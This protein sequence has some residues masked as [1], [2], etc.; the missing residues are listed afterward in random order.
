M[1]PSLG[2]RRGLAG[3]GWSVFSI[4]EFGRKFRPISH[5]HYMDP[6]TIS[7]LTGLATNYFAGFTMPVIQRFFDEAFGRKPSL[8]DDLKNA[9]SHADYERVFRE[10]VGVIDAAA[11][12][13]SIA[14]DSAFLS[15]VRGIRFDHQHGTVTIQ[16][17]TMMAPL[18]QMG[19]TNGSRGV[20]SL[21]ANTAL[22]SGGASIQIG[23]GISIVISG[24][25]SI[26]QS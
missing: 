6:I 22:N 13:G 26:R 21:G 15:A 1:V 20:T 5:R 14:V 23:E 4:I 12:S 3:Y 8:E 25:A 11:G 16:G 10:A 2:G 17:T 19:G 18:I 7:I 24:D 9:A